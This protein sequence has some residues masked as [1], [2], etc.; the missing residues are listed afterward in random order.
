[1][2]AGE[3][4]AVVVAGFYDDVALLAE[5]GEVIADA[6]LHFLR[7][8]GAADLGF[9]FFEGLQASLQV[10]VNFQDFE[11]GAGL[12]HVGDLAFAHL[13]DG[14]VR[15]AG[16]VS[17]FLNMPRASRH[18]SRCCPGNKGG[19]RPGRKSIAVEDADAE[20]FD[21]A[22]HGGHLF[23]GFSFGAERDF[24]QHHAL[25]QREFLRVRIV[26]LAHFFFGDF[27][28]RTDFTRRTNIYSF[29]SKP[30]RMVV[31]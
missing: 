1:M 26:I 25:G 18:L 20:A 19:G 7:E 10:I 13:E 12:D 3:Q 5:F 29:C 30:L 15:A 21:L 27:H 31:L 4:G 9:H 23:G 11:I 16:L 8:D 22:A 6:G 14:L 24:R 2:A 17:P 28:M